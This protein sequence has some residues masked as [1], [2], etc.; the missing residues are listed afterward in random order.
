MVSRRS[1]WSQRRIPCF[2][3]GRYNPLP[4]DGEYQT[5]PFMLSGLSRAPWRR[6]SSPRLVPGDGTAIAAARHLGDEVP[7][8]RSGTILHSCETWL[9]AASA[10]F[11]KLRPR[12]WRAL[13]AIRA[14][15]I[16]AVLHVAKVD[17]TRVG[18]CGLFRRE[19]LDDPDIGFAV[20]P[21]YCGVGLAGEAAA[22]VVAHARDDLGI[23]YLTAIVSPEN[24]RR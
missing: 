13:Q 6:T 20:L 17:G 1:S 22:A 5:V 9:T 10:R 7:C 23:E 15:R 16:R 12:S 21:D 18:I 11:S 19:N 4:I 14:A 8:C 2:A 3:N 24:R